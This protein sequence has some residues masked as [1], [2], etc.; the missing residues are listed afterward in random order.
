MEVDNLK[1]SF[2]NMGDMEIDVKPISKPIDFG[3]VSTG[4]RELAVQRR[5]AREE[6][7]RQE[8]EQHQRFV[9]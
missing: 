2:T 9:G 6:K 8:T 1:F 3:T 5:M 7:R 4:A